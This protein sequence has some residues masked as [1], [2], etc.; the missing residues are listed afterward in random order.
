[1]ESLLLIPDIS[2]FTRFVNET[3]VTHSRHIIAE[4]LELIIDAD[5]LGLTVGEI[6][7]DAVL[8]Y[9]EDGVPAVDELITQSRETFLRFHAHLKEYEVRRLCQCGACTT[10]SKLTLK[11]IAHR[12]PVDFIRIKNFKK[13]HGVDTILAHKLLKNSVDG[14]EYLLLTEPF[15]SAERDQGAVTLPEWVTLSEGKSAY[16]DVGEVA[17]RFVSLEALHAEVPDPAPPSLFER[18]NRPLIEETR[19]PVSPAAMYELV[20]RLDLR[21]IWTEG[22]D[23]FEFEEDRVTR[24]GT[25]HRCLVQGQTIDFETTTADFE[26]DRL[27]YGEVVRENPLV[28]RFALF[29]L[30]DED[31]GGSRV[32]LE[33]HYHPKRFPRNAL[34]PLFRL[35]GRRIARK[36]IEQLSAAVAKMA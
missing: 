26:G 21:P 13:P 22:I 31:N 35:V 36:V 11:F 23:E 4:L 20:S 8:F 32:R 6:E 9:S 27:V 17:Y 34:S 33:L 16:Q 19:V 25:R 3:E 2:G 29:W 1:M 10:A 7:G 24:V 14:R 18:T 28:D 15:F 30:I 5:Q 12:G